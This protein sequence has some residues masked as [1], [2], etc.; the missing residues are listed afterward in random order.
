VEEIDGQTWAVFHV[1]CRADEVEAQYLSIYRDWLPDSGFEPA[2]LPAYE[3]PGKKLEHK[4]D[5]INHLE[6]FLPVKPI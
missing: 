2:D 6:I 4:M 5:E 3:E 1:K